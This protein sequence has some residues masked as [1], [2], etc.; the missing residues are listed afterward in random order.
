MKLFI[1]TAQN[2]IKQHIF[3]CGKHIGY[4][5]PAAELLRAVAATQLS[6]TR[7][8]EQQS[9]WFVKL[10][11]W[12]LNGARLQLCHTTVELWALFSLLFESA[13]KGPPIPSGTRG[14]FP[15]A[16]QVQW[17]SR[18]IFPWLCASN[19]S[20]VTVFRVLVGVPGDLH[21][22]TSEAAINHV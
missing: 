9:A 11:L 7:H 2:V 22:S 21:M 4:F 5:C 10:L 13:I 8:L 3:A 1:C 19:V 14:Y 18:R 15:V 6:I 20:C 16:T 12:Q 17:N